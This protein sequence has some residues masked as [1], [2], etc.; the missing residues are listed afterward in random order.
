MQKKESRKKKSIYFHPLLSWTKSKEHLH[1]TVDTSWKHL[2]ADA[3]NNVLPP[4]RK[5]LQ[6]GRGS[7]G[8]RR[9]GLVEREEKLCLVWQVA[10]FI[11]I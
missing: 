1:L 3:S 7:T 10:H 4:A 5:D 6:A 8:R 2:Q 11:V 9:L